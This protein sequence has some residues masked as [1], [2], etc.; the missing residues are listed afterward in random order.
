MSTNDKDRSKQ[1]T[2]HAFL[3]AA[4]KLILERG[5]DTVTVA[6]IAR[7]ADYGRSTFYL[8]FEDKEALVWA[9]LRH[10]MT[11]LDEHIK[12]AT[13]GLSS[14]MREFAAWKIIFREID[15]Q[16]E[17]FL[18]LDGELSRRLRQWQKTLLIARFEQQLRDGLYSIMLDVPPELGARF[19]VGAILEILDYWLM[20]PEQ[21]SADDMARMFY[22][23]VFRRP[24]EEAT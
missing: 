18:Q 3:E 19:I 11:A 14:P 10:H 12:K 17:F 8:H 16:R 20:H 7:E 23:L 2:A 1:R 4:T 5:Y 13:A 6:D 21:G 22:H 24:P 9:L 15:G